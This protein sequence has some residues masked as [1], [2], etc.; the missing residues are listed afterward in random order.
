[1]KEM[2]MEAE[3]RF[4]EEEACSQT[5]Q[6]GRV[7]SAIVS[8]IDAD[9]ESAVLGKEQWEMIRSR[10]EA[11]E[12]VSAI[13]RELGLDRKTVR[14]SLGQAQWQ[15]YQR[16]AVS[17]TLLQPHRAWLEKRAPEVRYSA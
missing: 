14:R 7:R 10:R 16:R 3:D 17:S 13:A 4:I 11:G 5:Q 12:T 8:E 1:M 9:R 15:A 6:D 2:A